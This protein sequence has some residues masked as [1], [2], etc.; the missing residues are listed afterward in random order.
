MDIYAYQD[1]PSHP[2]PSLWPSTLKTGALIGV[3][4]DQDTIFRCID[5]VGHYSRTFGFPHEST[6]DV[7]KDV[8]RFLSNLEVEAERSPSM[9]AFIF[10]TVA[11]GSLLVESDEQPPFKRSSGKCQGRTTDVYSEFYSVLVNLTTYQKCT[12]CF[13][14]D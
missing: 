3:L 8:E 11:E 2:F 7:N 10:A 12:D 1:A 9:L 5:A 4:P 13:V 14:F 6:V